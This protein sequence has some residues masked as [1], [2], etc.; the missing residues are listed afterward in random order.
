M[1]PEAPV[2]APIDRNSPMAPPFTLAGAVTGAQAALVVSPAIVVF[3]G[4]F[5]M[6]A[7]TQGIGLWEATLMSAV[8]C[9]GTAQFA[10]LQLWTD[11]VSW[12]TV[13]I[14]SLVMNARYVLLGATLRGWF[15]NL[16]AAK[17]YLS[18]FMMYDGNWAT[19]TRDHAK[20]YRDAAHLIGGGIVMCTIWTL[21]TMSGHAFGG[22]VGDPRA[23]GLDFV[24][25]A[26]FAAMS[27]TFWRGRSDAVP[28]V[29]A[30]AAAVVVDRLLPGPWYIVAGAVLG[31]LV[32]AIR[33]VP[34]AGVE[35]KPSADRAR[36]ADRDAS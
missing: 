36:K 22:L 27:I 16:P 13:G 24:I 18:M 8:V 28:V 31:S 30:V 10:A 3:G 5:G 29:V 2:E 19:A 12:V 33:F 9:A 23:F 14:A 21:A 15:A 34:A 1:Q 17:A 11:P 7:A 26:F 4:T 32:A 35:A 6:L 25:T 20:G